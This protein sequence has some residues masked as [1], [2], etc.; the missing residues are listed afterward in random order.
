MPFL[1]RGFC[2]HFDGFL[3]VVSAVFERVATLEVRF[4]GFLVAK[5]RFFVGVATPVRRSDGLGRFSSPEAEF[6]KDRLP[7]AT[8]WRVSRR[9][10][11]NFEGSI[12]LATF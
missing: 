6:G 11:Q 4:G 7:S 3:V 1:L 10:K 5:S 2:R 8:I 9:Q 12:S